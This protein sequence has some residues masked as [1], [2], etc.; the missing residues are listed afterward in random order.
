MRVLSWIISIILHVVAAL[1]LTASTNIPIPDEVPLINVELTTSEVPEDPPMV[2]PAPA[3]GPEMPQLSSSIRVAENNRPAPAPSPTAKPVSTTVSEKKSSPQKTS[4]PVSINTAESRGEEAAFMLKLYSAFYSYSPSEFAG[5]FQVEGG[6]VLTIID[7]RKTSYGRLLLYDSKRRELRRL[8]RFGKYIYTIGPS[9]Y[10]DEPVTGSV[11]FLAGD[12]RIN[13]F[14]YMPEGE[15]AFYPG[16]THFRE[17][18]GHPELSGGAPAENILTLPPEEG[19]YPGMVLLHGTECVAANMVQ[20]TTRAFSNEGIALTAFS[21]QKCFDGKKNAEALSRQITACVKLFRE[22]PEV[23]DTRVGLLGIGDGVSLALKATSF[24]KIDV[25]F[26]VGLIDWSSIPKIERI[27]RLQVPSL[28]VVTEDRRTRRFL[29]EL[30]TLRDAK[31]RPVTIMLVKGRE[32]HTGNSIEEKLAETAIT[33]QAPVGRWIA[34]Q[35]GK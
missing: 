20:G 18:R 26:L 32:G 7:A 31:K 24:P 10:E 12:D 8:K 28:W 11:T 25:S 14:I 1:T 6:R 19:K 27:A 22:N 35:T 13:R 23:D 9:L 3:Q 33:N 21:A 16:K 17:K 15:K 4:Y 5:H 30:R 34:Q 29:R 2:I